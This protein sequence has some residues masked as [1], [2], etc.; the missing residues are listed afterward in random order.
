MNEGWRGVAGGIKGRKLLAGGSCVA[1][2]TLNRN[3]N[4]RDIAGISQSFP[5][6]ISQR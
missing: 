4:N 6:G 5:T 3:I 1:V 2:L